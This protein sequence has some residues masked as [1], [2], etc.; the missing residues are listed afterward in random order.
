MAEITDEQIEELGQLADKAAN[1]LAGSFMKVPDSIH[2]VGLRGGM[3]DIR[4]ALRDL[5]VKLGDGE[6]PWEFEP[7]DPPGMFED[8]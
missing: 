4:N 2:V 6:N 5:V 3:R 1:L 8:E 7:P